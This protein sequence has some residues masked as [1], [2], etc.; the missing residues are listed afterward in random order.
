[1]SQPA[2]DEMEAALA[3]LRA[4]QER[5]QQAHGQIKAIFGTSTSKDRMVSATVD[6]RGRL[7]DL[8]I[9]GSRYRQMAPAELSDRIVE[10]VRSAQDQA[11]REALSMFS[12]LAPSGMLSV[13]NGGFDFESMFDAA[14]ETASE[15]LFADGGPMS[16]KREN[17]R[18]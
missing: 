3:S 11:A 17:P 12:G 9:A 14:V 18:G 5:I 8:R 4:Q 1:M 7:T 6:A 2:G 10:T 13:L 15:P 16:A